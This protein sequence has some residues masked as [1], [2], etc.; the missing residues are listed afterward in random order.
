MADIAVTPLTLVA[1]TA[2]A[3]T[4]DASCT[5]IAAAATNVWAIAAGGKP[6][7]RIVLKFVGMASSVI[8]ILAGARPPSQRAGLGNLTFAIANA[9]VKYIIV[10]TG[11]HLQANGTIRASVDT[12]DTTKC[13]A[14]IIPKFY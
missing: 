6:G 5:S 7:D 14:F 10:D 1:G 8:S 13:G 12:G 9:E 11:R 4:T 3:T 2:S